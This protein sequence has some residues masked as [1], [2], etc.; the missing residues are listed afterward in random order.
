[1]VPLF[2]LYAWR[3]F[4]FSLFLVASQGFAI[5]SFRLAITPGEKAIRKRKKKKRN[6]TNKLPCLSLYPVCFIV[7][8][9]SYL[10]HM[11]TYVTVQIKTMAILDFKCL[12]G[13]YLA[14][15]SLPEYPFGFLSG[16]PM[17]ARYCFGWLV[18]YDHRPQTNFEWCFASW[19]TFICLVLHSPSSGPVFK[20]HL[21][22]STV[23][24]T[25]IL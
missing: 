20:R 7:K 1:M 15:I 23:T 13:V 24:T 5:S 22:E 6:D 4:V 17:V 2:R 16:G 9:F 10:Q 25:E 14:S 21:T 12:L 18:S 3:Y 8:E 11:S 19:S